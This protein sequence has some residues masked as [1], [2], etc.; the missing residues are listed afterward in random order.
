[1]SRELNRFVVLFQQKAKLLKS[2]KDDGNEAY[3]T[4]KFQEAFELYSKALAIDPD[5]VSTCAKL[6]YNRGI[7]AAR[8]MIKLL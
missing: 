7:V 3:K 1:M 5:N 2:T 6:F 8:V 4:G